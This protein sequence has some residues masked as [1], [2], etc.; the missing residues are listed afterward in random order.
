MRMVSILC[1][2][3]MFVACSRNPNVP[4]GADT[5]STHARLV[6]PYTTTVASLPGRE[7]G[8]QS[9]ND[10]SP[11]IEAVAQQAGAFRTK[12]LGDFE[13]AESAV[14]STNA[15]PDAA[16]KA[17]PTPEEMKTRIALMSNLRAVGECCA[18]AFYQ[19]FMNTNRD[20]IVG[21]LQFLLQRRL[22]TRQSNAVHSSVASQYVYMRQY[23][24]ALAYTDS[25]IGQ[26]PPV[27]MPLLVNF[28]IAKNHAYRGQL[29]DLIKHRGDYSAAQ[30]D[31]LGR[32]LRQN[33][34]ANA[35][36]WFSIPRSH[37]PREKAIYEDQYVRDWKEFEDA[38]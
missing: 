34:D 27:D 4:H 18:Y 31:E 10:D 29:Y 13:Q 17:R 23:D 30:Y 36:L 11:N 32:Q 3:A 19:A 22:D 14:P 7:P 1:M 9:N 35:S 5:N 28:T 20:E 25:I 38:K 21:L 6:L 2:T 24:K 37:R 8:I 26:N 12:V 16:H 33:M 15:V